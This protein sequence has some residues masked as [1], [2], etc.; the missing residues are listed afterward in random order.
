MRAKLA[1]VFLLF[2]LLQIALVG[3]T[4]LIT[5]S[6]GMNFLFGIIFYSFLLLLVF[7]V[8]LYFIFWILKLLRF[9]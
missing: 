5:I 2:C 3:T 6:I 1:L 9:K 8:D 4:S 7:I